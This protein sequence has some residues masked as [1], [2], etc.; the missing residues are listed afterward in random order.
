MSSVSERRTG[1][2]T[3]AES[4]ALRQAILDETLRALRNAGSERLSIDR[5]AAQIDVTKRTIYRHFKSKAGL[6]DAVVTRE[7]DRLTVAVSGPEESPDRPVN[8]ALAE[9]QLWSRLI[10]DHMNRAEERAFRRYLQFEAQSDP[11]IRDHLDRWYLKLFDHG[12]R[13]VGAAQN[14]GSIGPGKP[15]R[16]TS[17]LFDLVF[18]SEARWLFKNPS[19]AL[20]GD[21]ADTYFRLRWLAFLSLTG[22]HAWGEF[23]RE[24]APDAPRERTAG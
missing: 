21:D 7:I 24:M 18:G 2:P 12:C 3:T 5:V 11:E 1:R 22:H 23:V 19:V 9:L 20:G 16:L 10:F 14:E 15:P 17:L 13:L 4:I 6:I 8:G